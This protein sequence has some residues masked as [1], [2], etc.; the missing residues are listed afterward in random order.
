MKIVMNLL[1]KKKEEKMLLTYKKLNRERR[2]QKWLKIKNI[3]KL[4]SNLE[5]SYL[6]DKK[7]SVSLRQVIDKIS[8]EK[9]L[10]DLDKVKIRSKKVC[11]ECRVS[12]KIEEKKVKFVRKDGEQLDVN[13]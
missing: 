9:I 3:Q 10:K 5:W 1:L 6:M 11:D 8:R 4:F 12:L 7:G 13:K 2:G